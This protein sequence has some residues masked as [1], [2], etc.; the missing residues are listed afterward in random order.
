LSGANQ[1]GFDSV[2]DICSNAGPSHMQPSESQPFSFESFQSNCSSANTES[3]RLDSLIDFDDDNNV[4]ELN[5]STS[6]NFLIETEPNCSQVLLNASTNHTSVRVEEIMESDCFNS[7][8]NEN[9]D[10]EE[11]DDSLSTPPP[12]YEEVVDDDSDDETP[13]VVDYGTL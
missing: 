2:V 9:L 4:S 3:D 8:S 10:D 12:S 11:I 6:N 5:P 13:I 1:F 7:Y